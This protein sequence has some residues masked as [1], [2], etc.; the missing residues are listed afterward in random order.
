MKLTGSI[1]S[2]LVISFLAVSFLTVFLV[3]SLSYYRARKALVSN[4]YQRLEA[5]IDLKEDALDRWI[6]EKIDAL[7]FVRTQPSVQE[8]AATL[9]KG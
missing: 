7:M 9:L 5:T 6:D 1:I 4:L 3:G 8:N 2:R